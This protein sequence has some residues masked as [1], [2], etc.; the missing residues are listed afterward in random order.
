MSKKVAFITGISGMAGSH[1][2]EYLLENTDWNIVGLTRWRSPLD[3]IKALVKIVDKG[4]RLSLEYGDITDSTSINSIIKKV[5]PDYMFH[6]A[7]QSYPSSS[8][9]APLDTLSTNILG[10]TVILEALKK[11]SR[12]CITHVCASSEI[13]GKV[14]KEKTPINEDCAFHPLSPYAISKVGA[15][16]LGRYY[17]EAFNMTIMTTR[18][19]TH[20]G[21][22][23]GD[24]FAES[25]FAKQIAMIEN[26]L[27]E[28][29][30]KVGN[31]DSLRTIADVRDAVRAYY[32]L[33][34]VNPTKG[35]YY[36]IGGTI[37]CTI[38]D[39]LKKLIS[40]STKKDTIKI[41]TDPTRLRPIDANIQVPDMT[42]F[43]SHTGW[44]PE[45]SFDKT[46]T[47]LL[48]YWREQVQNKDNVF[49]KR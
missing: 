43:Q 31:L 37:S 14:P 22:R 8:F 45:I 41:E 13:F 42:K 2:A 3:N 33:V 34:T 21:P 17:A 10:T 6:L 39:V 48:N 44:K 23:R 47:D 1:L 35:G 30:V 5:K 18:M 11:Y 19:F 7:A 27:M 28:P 40:L 16:L 29:I 38:G 12:D 15:D 46:M 4:E 32:M 49:L 36:N 9:T 20:T 25:T 26:G 24:V